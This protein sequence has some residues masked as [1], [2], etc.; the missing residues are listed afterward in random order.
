MARIDSG[1]IKLDWSVYAGDAN[2]ELFA[3][4]TSDGAPVNLSGV[5][6][7]AQAR[8]T[9]PDTLVA[10]DAVVTPKDLALGQFYVQWD[11][12][13]L[14][15]LLA[16]KGQWSGVWDLQMDSGSP[17]G[18]E[19]LLAGLFTVTHDVTRAP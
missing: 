18:V 6:L 13:Q 10:A 8:A 7:Q 14:R 2:R 3:V 5:T 19:T 11:G 9:A 4:S 1:P 15:A 12:A 17:G 16:G